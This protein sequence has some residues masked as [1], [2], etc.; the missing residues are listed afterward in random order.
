MVKN[1]IFNLNPGNIVFFNVFKYS[2]LS[3][4]VSGIFFWFLS[5]LTNMIWI[6]IE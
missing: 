6:N 1:H 5:R 4:F 3:L 2:D